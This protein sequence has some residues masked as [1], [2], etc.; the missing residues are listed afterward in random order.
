MYAWSLF[1]SRK[2]VFGSST[3]RCCER[4][5]AKADP[6]PHRRGVSLIQPYRITADVGIGHLPSPNMHIWRQWSDGVGTSPL[7]P[8]YQGMWETD[9]RVRHYWNESCQADMR[10]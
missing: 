5:G 3:L 1:P 2:H 8:A 7:D 6:P 9:N 4:V 10:S